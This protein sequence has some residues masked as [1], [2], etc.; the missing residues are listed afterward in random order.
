MKGSRGTS[1]SVTIP[2]QTGDIEVE[3]GWWRK[4]QHSSSPA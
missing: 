3:D 1:V 4:I 2:S